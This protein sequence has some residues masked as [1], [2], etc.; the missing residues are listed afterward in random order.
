MI[1]FK[2]RAEKNI[3]GYKLFKLDQDAY[4]YCGFFIATDIADL[5]DQ[6]GV[7]VGDILDY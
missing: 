2:F 4:I 5:A 1:V 6:L 3:L 7:C